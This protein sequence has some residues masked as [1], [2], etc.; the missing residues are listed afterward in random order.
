MLGQARLAMVTA[1][2]AAAALAVL[3]NLPVAQGEEPS[4]PHEQ[5]HTR[6]VVDVSHMGFVE[7][8]ESVP[9]ETTLDLEAL[10]NTPAVWREM[11]L[12][13]RETIDIETF[14]VSSSGIDSDSLEPV[15]ATLAHAASRG[16]RI[17]LLAD[18]AFYETYPDVVE[19]IGALP[20]ALARILGAAGLWGGVL[21]AKFFV[22]DNREM[23]IGSQNWDWR[24]LEHIHELGVRIRHEALARA[25]GAVFEMD[26]ALAAGAEDAPAGEA[27]LGVLA[28]SLV[29]GGPYVLH[30]SAGQ[31]VT[32]VLAASPR[33]ALPRG[34]SWDEP[35]LVQAIDGAR[36]DVRLQLL[37]FNP[38]DAEGRY[39]QSLEAALKRAAARGVQV[40]VILSNWSLR[41]HILPYVLSLAAVPGIHVRITTIPEWS[42]GFVPYARVEHAKYLIADDQACWIGTSNWT[43]DGFHECRN[44]SVFFYGSGVAAQ[45][46]SFFD[47]SWGSEYAA[48]VDPCQTYS[49]PRITP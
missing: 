27:A 35:F 20:G 25:L 41:P 46:T 1:G 33:Q 16:V 8:V 15:L 6:R 13:A 11:I 10:R 38:V 17:R 37:T 48:D 34:I 9:I 23:F 12:D 36:S 21:H 5:A 26:W 40:R 28:D 30:T 3:A 43:R 22:V 18:A 49:A 42:G 44:L 19:R 31:P 24:A 47:G 7:L 39:H 32:T 4:S 14:Y 45:A 2:G 29:S